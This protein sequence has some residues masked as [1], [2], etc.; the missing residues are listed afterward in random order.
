MKRPLDFYQKSGYR[1]ETSLSLTLLGR[2]YQDKGEDDTALKSFDQ[3]LQVVKEAGDEA[4]IADS[5][6]NVA[7]L[8]GVNQERYTEALAELNEKLR[9]DE[10]RK[11]DR[12]K[13]F[14]Q[15]N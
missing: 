4:G 9:I 6:M 2:A 12:G 10:A 5:H 1:R 14:A 8:R 7:L 11:S 13:A 3:Q 15:M